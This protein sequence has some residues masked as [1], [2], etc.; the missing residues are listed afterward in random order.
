[1][2]ED[3][4]EGDEGDESTSSKVV[5]DKGPSIGMTMAQAD[6]LNELW[7]RVRQFLNGKDDQGQDV[8]H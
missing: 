1:M 3:A 6:Q 8:E 5:K 4:A 7:Q 2:M